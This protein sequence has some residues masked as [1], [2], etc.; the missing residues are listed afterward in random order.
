MAYRLIVSPRVDR[1]LHYVYDWG[2]Q[3][4]G[5][6]AAR[7]FVKKLVASLSDIRKH[8]FSYSVESLLNGLSLEYRSMV[9]HPY[10]K[11]IFYVDEP[12]KTIY[13]VDL[14]D[15]RMDPVDL[16]YYFEKYQR[17]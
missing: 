2:V 14:W 1:V 5:V 16:V 4:S 9:A 17:K 8:P 6:K 3:D 11:F 13:I 15:T 12:S 7:T 10:F